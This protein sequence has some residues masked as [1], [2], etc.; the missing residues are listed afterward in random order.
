MASQF[1]AISMAQIITEDAPARRQR[2]MEQPD[3]GWKL[4]FMPW[5]FLEN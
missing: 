3:S 2:Q 1:G 5:N 4:G